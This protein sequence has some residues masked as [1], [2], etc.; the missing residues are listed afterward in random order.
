MTVRSRESADV[1]AVTRRPQHRRSPRPSA[2]HG[3]R[4]PISVI[5]CC[6]ASTIMKLARPSAI[7]DTG[8]AEL[9]RPKADRDTARPS[10]ARQFHCDNRVR[11]PVHC[12]DEPV[13]GV[14]GRVEDRGWNTGPVDG[15]C[16]PRDRIRVA[17]VGVRARRK[18]VVVAAQRRRRLGSAKI[19]P[20]VVGQLARRAYQARRRADLRSGHG[21]S[22][23]PA[24]GARSPADIRVEGVVGEEVLRGRR[25]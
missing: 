18:R 14:L 22:R 23:P 3:P 6:C 9:S 16:P 5:G 19:D 20:D 13:D 8:A 4:R 15:A 10:R 2:N 21:R 1:F 25:Q 12:L 11:H 24:C 17:L 7:E